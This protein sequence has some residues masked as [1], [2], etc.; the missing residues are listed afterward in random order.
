M[1]ERPE[2]HQLGRINKNGNFE[3]GNCAWMNSKQVSTNKKISPPRDDITGRTFGEWFVVSKSDEKDWGGG[4]KY[5]CRCSCGVEA[6]IRAPN[7]RYGGSSKCAVCRVSKLKSSLGSAMSAAVR[8]QE[9]L[10]KQFNNWTV[11]SIGPN[12]TPKGS[13]LYLC[14]CSCGVIQELDCNKLKSGRTKS[15]INC[16]IKSDRG[17]ICLDCGCKNHKDIDLEA[18]LC[19]LLGFCGRCDG[20]THQLVYL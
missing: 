19:E 1:G 13:I 11:K 18:S 12:R 8:A 6:F 7:L 20:Y 10:G 3:P 4:F 16:Y 5:L 9:V 15:C 14:E 2:G 17:S